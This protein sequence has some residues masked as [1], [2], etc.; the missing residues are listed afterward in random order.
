M[1]VLQLSLLLVY[2]PIWAWD[3]EARSRTQPA[4][5]GVDPSIHT[6]NGDI[7]THQNSHQN[8]VADGGNIKAKYHRQLCVQGQNT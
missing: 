4:P 2:V 6:R 5:R 7:N 3:P 1:W 8:P